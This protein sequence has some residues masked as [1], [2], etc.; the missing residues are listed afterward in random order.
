[1]VELDR[2]GNLT[3]PLLEALRSYAV[4]TREVPR[5]NA[6]ASSYLEQARMFATKPDC[7]NP[8]AMEEVLRRCEKVDASLEVERTEIRFEG[9]SNFMRDV[10]TRATE[11]TDPIKAKRLVND[12][13]RYFERYQTAATALNK[14]IPKEVHDMRAIAFGLGLHLN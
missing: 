2:S 9:Y 11:G 12:F 13:I 8:I 14:E 6:K 4:G 5:I 10:L 7:F 3:Y 1:M